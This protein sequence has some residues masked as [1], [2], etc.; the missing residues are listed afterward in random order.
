MLPKRRLWNVEPMFQNS[1]P[2]EHFSTFC[3]PNN[4][5]TPLK[6]ACK[7]HSVMLV[8]PS[9]LRLGGV[10]GNMQL[11]NLKLLVYNNVNIRLVLKSTFPIP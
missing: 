10:Q 8:R 7:T 11:R 6:S 1:F 5:L 4:V 9:N 2:W 3:S